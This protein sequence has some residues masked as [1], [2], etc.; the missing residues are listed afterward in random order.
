MIRITEE[1]WLNG[2]SIVRLENDLLIVDVAPSIGGRITSITEKKTSYQFLWHSP[3][4]PLNAHAPGSAYDPVFWGGIDELLPCDIPEVVNGISLPD[5]GELWTTPLSYRIDEES[6]VLEADLDVSGLRYRKS[7][8]LR[9]DTF[10]CDLD[11]ELTNPTG[12]VVEFQWRL[13]APV[14]VKPGDRLICPAAKARVAD[15]PNSRFGSDQPFDWPV[16][17]G[18]CADVVPEMNGETESFYLWDLEVGVISWNNAAETLC[19]GLTFDTDVFPYGYIFASYGGFQ[20]GE[21]AILEPS[22]AMPVSLNEARALGQCA[23]L[24]PGEK[25]ETRIA[26]YAGTMSPEKK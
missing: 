12:H 24:S 2:I 5:H 13:H 15:F 17:D 19:F 20:G 22:A 11:Y 6:L 18:V 7:V 1:T 25:L 10:H 23:R 9:P 14:K 16:Q 21:F 26:I 3:Q 4:L 8:S